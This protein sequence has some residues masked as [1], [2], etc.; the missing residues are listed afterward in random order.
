MDIEDIKSINSLDYKEIGLKIK[1]ARKKK[2][3][4]QEELGKK[5]NRSTSL[6]RKYEKGERKIPIHILRALE[7]ILEINLLMDSKNNGI[8]IVCRDI[9]GTVGKILNEK[10]IL[11]NK[12]N[13]TQDLEKKIDSIINSDIQDI[14]YN[15]HNKIL[16]KKEKEKLKDRLINYI[17]SDLCNIFSD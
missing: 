10:I 13:V 16:T 4:T 3:L 1:N 5:I 12:I 8:N 17:V 6:I 9:W 2:K 15:H 14:Y 11:K 7:I